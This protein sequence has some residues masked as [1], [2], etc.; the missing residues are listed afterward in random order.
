MRS[1]L[2]GARKNKAGLNPGTT[3]ARG[4][5]VLRAMP[6]PKPKLASQE[7]GGGRASQ[8]LSPTSYRSTKTQRFRPL[9]PVIKS[10]LSRPGIYERA[11]TT[12]AAA[13]APPP[14]LTPPSPAPM[15]PGKCSSYSPYELAR[16]RLGHMQTTTPSN[17]TINVARGCALRALWRRALINSCCSEINPLRP[18]PCSNR[19]CTPLCQEHEDSNHI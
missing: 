2:S 10:P 7:P 19:G 18:D 12:T 3:A 11:A 15:T 6:A 1:D 13:R 14:G 9:R 16:R 4:L 17:T 5:P 8:L